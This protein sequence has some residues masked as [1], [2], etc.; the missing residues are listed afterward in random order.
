MTAGVSFLV[1]WVVEGALVAGA[2]AWHGRA[3][4][5]DQGV[6]TKKKAQALDEGGTKKPRAKTPQR[7][8]LTEHAQPAEEAVAKLDADLTAEREQPA[9][10]AEKLE[11]EAEAARAAALAKRPGLVRL[12]AAKLDAEKA[13]ADLAERTGRAAADKKLGELLA[14][15]KLDADLGRAAADLSAELAR[16]A[17]AVVKIGELLVLAKLDAD[18][19]MAAADLAT[20]QERRRRRRKPAS[21]TPT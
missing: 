2:V 4:G 11:R 18:L 15:T 3:T 20:E 8:T 16:H 21:S 13:A 19:V 17:D 10:D 6:A 9:E 5:G 1:S 7:A 14:I 12:V